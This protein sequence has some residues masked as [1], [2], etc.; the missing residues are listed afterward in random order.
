M[1]TKMLKKLFIL[2]LSCFFIGCGGAS[3]DKQEIPTE[4][5]KLS[6]EVS[7]ITSIGGNITPKSQLILTGNTATLNVAADNE[8]E[9]ESIVGC[10]GQLSGNIYTTGR[11]T[12]ACEISAKFKL[13][14]HS[15][16]ATASQGG[17]V[18]P[19]SQLI[20]HGGVAVV[21]I[22]A[23]AGFDIDK[24]EG[25]NGQ[26]NG[27]LYTTG[28]ITAA[29]EVSAKFKLKSYTVT[30]TA[31]EGGTVTPVSQLIQHGGVA[32]VNIAAAA[33]FDIDKVEGCNGQL[34]G[35]LYTTSSIT[36]ACEVSAKFKIKIH[37][38][39]ASIPDTAVSITPM[40]QTVEHGGR[41]IF[42]TAQNTGV[43]Q[44]KISGCGG[45]LKD[46]I[47]IIDSV[48][49]DCQIMAEFTEGILS[50][51]LY[52]YHEDSSIIV[53]MDLS[54]VNVPNTDL[55]YLIYKENGVV[56]SSTEEVNRNY[57]TSI[58]MPIARNVYK[59]VI[60]NLKPDS[61]YEV[62]MS[63][64]NDFKTTGF[65]GCKKIKTAPKQN[66][67]AIIIVNHDVEPE[68]VVLIEKWMAAVK[69][70]NQHIQADLHKIQPGTSAAV[71]KQSLKDSYN[72]SNLKHVV[73]IGYDV[74]ALA[75]NNT[76]TKYLGMYSSLSNIVKGDWH[77]EHEMGSGEV[78]VAVIKPRDTTVSQYFKR[79][80]DHYDGIN[81]YP[82]RVL[83]ADAQIDSEK[84][85][86]RKD[87]EK[88]N[89]E[90][91]MVTG[92]KDYNDLS[93]AI[94]WQDGYSRNLLENKY[95]I[96]F[97]GAHGSTELHY[98]CA[99]ECI[100]YNFIEK[101][102]PKTKF[103]IAISCNIGHVLTYGSPI[104]SYIFG[105]NSGSLSGLASEVLYFDVN[106]S[107]GRRIINELKIQ[108]KSIGDVSRSFGFLVVGDPF[109]TL[110]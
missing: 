59:K 80:N 71:L 62:C 19:V 106:G 58:R 45:Y 94:R 33:G 85:F 1:N 35:N 6:Y 25:C 75:D 103:V 30:A 18:T 70:S 48:T 23:A 56:H 34:N 11:I 43:G 78:T 16:T 4:P 46:S 31:S 87:F 42:Y 50:L 76:G 24:V 53:S 3:S 27:N 2:P 98:P 39:T 29:C 40:A 63:G 69:R 92:I 66:E 44:Y 104:I 12:S 15:V 82:R 14:S 21:N 57:S 96:L 9:I 90:I 55:G 88:F 5:A 37:T 93:E 83:L 108:K 47:Y 67:K 60:S 105:K 68:A 17:A 77:N 28:S 13:K 81:I 54:Q 95:E 97:I 52:P 10:N 41:L 99:Y 8:Y 64:M 26:L 79:L 74:P 38:V 110:I 51:D 91:D 102:E 100:D 22:A 32:V 49:S 7:A 73:F 101:A 84:T 86:F 109:L 65:F 20:Q 107:S 61:E 36:A 72:S 89:F